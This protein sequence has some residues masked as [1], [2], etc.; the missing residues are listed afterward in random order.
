MLAPVLLPDAQ[1]IQFNHL[2]VG[3]C[4]VTVFL[5]A[6]QL[7][8]ECPVCAQRSHSVH[9]RYSRTVADLPWAGVPV[10][11]QLNVRK[12]FCRNNACGRTIFTERLPTVVGP[13]ARRSLRLADQQHW[14]GLAVGAATAARAGER[15]GLPASADT[16]LRLFHHH[17]VPARPTPRSLGVDDWA[18]RKG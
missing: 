15:L 2:T 1:F 6:I 9:S 10:R 11:L 16:M 13:W 3:V 4:Q 7:A 5:T 17:P 12:F 8:A 14:L 18:W